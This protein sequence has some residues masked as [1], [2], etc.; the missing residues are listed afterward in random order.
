MSV[1]VRYAPS[2]TG[3]PHVGN[4][5]TALYNHLF[6]K[7]FGGVNILRF[8]D[9]DRSR[10]RPETEVDLIESLRFV[11]VEWQEG[12]EVGGPHAPYRQSERKEAGIYQT[13]IDR[14]VE[15]GAAY[16]AFD[17]PDE[18]DEMRL[19]QQVNKLPTGYFGGD[20]REASA[21]K[22]EE[23]RAAGRPGVLRLRIPRG[24]KI[25]FEDAIRGRLEFEGDTVDDPVLIKA[26]GMPTYHFAAMVDDHLMGITNIFRGEEWISSAPKHVVLW[27]AL[28]VEPPVLVHLPVI[29]GRDGSKLSKR[30]GDTSCLDFRKAGYLGDALANFIALIGWAPGGD[31]EVMSME[32]MAEAFDLK[33][34]QPSSGIFDLDKLNWMQGARLRALPVAE[35]RERFVEYAG[36]EETASYWQ[37]KSEEDP[38]AAGRL[39]DILLLRE[40]AQS[41]PDHAEAM[42]A[43]EQERVGSLADFGPA[44]RFFLEDPTEY[45]EKAL[46]KWQ[47]RPEVLDLLVRLAA[48]LEGRESATDAD[49]EALIRGL[50]SDLG[51]EK[52]GPVVHPVRLALTGKSV[53]PG[54]WELMA[55]LGPAAM[56]R[57]LAAAVE[58]FA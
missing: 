49:C 29:K 45:E 53:G 6:A 43:L 58:A 1:R 57:R 31:R 25:V 24:E 48:A 35:V 8:E 20:W 33:G 47:G 40:A 56:R 22:V 19:F 17:T 2:P 36:R 9:T 54:L 7:R 55:V 50:A 3:S 12:M 44:C 51:H 46:K 16:W 39:A 28:G 5:R 52:L 41:D 4:I 37:A 23:A 32:E 11:G 14:L 26:D 42:I 27:R 34:I 30:H 38:T 18:L 15:S 10:H 21:A 13:F